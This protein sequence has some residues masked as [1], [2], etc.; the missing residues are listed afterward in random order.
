MLPVRR[1]VQ[2][3]LSHVACRKLIDARRL[4]PES[5]KIECLRPNPVRVVGLQRIEG[6][7]ND[8]ANALSFEDG[9]IP[10]AAAARAFIDQ[11]C[12]KPSTVGIEP[13]LVAALKGAR[14]AASA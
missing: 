1:L 4:L 13:D 7:G 8:V 11:P 12:I 14:A 6:N 10:G 5:L 2:Q 9:S 3:L